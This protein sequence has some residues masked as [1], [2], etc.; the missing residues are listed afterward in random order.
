MSYVPLLEKFL[1]T[2][3]GLPNDLQ[4][5]FATI[6]ALQSMCD[7]KESRIDTL[8]AEILTIANQPSPTQHETCVQLLTELRALQEE[9]YSIHSEQ[10]EL[11]NQARDII[12]GYCK[13]ADHDVKMLEAMLP[14]DALQDILT[15]EPAPKRE[16]AAPE[17][18]MQSLPTAGPV[19]I[20]HRKA[21]NAST[22]SSLP[23]AAPTF[24]STTSVSNVAAERAY[25]EPVA[26]VEPPAE[27]PV[28]AA[29]ET[30]EDLFC[31]CQKPS[32]GDMVGC[33]GEKCPYEWFHFDCVGLKRKPK[34]K[35]YCSDCAPHYS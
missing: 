17:P 2:L 21:S 12:Y 29:V 35:W 1:N 28:A 7:D 19:P 5:S 8:E 4:R 24:G 13:R 27:I 34:G 22:S 10:V 16:R 33:D 26:P 6:Q 18:A 30:A 15:Q 32:Y 25:V 14:P 20:I 3:K 31:T 11:A 9:V 23:R